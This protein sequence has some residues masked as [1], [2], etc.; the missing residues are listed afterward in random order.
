M[1]NTHAEC[2]PAL[3]KSASVHQHV[4]EGH[5]KTIESVPYAPSSQ[6]TVLH[7]ASST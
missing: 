3:V 7:C 6:H 1:C 2:T 4:R 5:L